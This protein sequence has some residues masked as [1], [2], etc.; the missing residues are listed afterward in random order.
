MRPRTAEELLK[1]PGMD[2]TTLDLHRAALLAALLAV[3][4]HHDCLD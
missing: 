4:A 3:L 2:E 1:V